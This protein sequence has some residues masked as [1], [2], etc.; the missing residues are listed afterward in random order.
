MAI[1]ALTIDLLWS[2]MP[3]QEQLKACRA[4]WD[5]DSKSKRAREKSLVEQLARS[6]NFHLKFVE[7]KAPLWK[8]ETLFN[9]LKNQEFKPYIGPILYEY[10]YDCKTEMVCAILD[11]EGTSH[12]GADIAENASPP[13][14]DALLRG[15]TAVRG[16]FPDFDIAIYYGYQFV[17]R[18]SR[19]WDAL[20][21][22]LERTAFRALFLSAFAH[23]H[24]QP[25][26]QRTMAGQ[27]EG[28][29]EPESNN[30]FT[31][32]DGQVIKAVVACATGVEGA[33]S[34]DALEDFIQEILSLNL[35]RHRSYFH[36]GY[37]NSIFKR[38][39]S[40]DFSGSNTSRRGWFLTGYLMGQL[41]QP[42]GNEVVGSIRANQRYW[43]ELLRE[44]PKGCTSML[45]YP[46]S[47]HLASAAEWPMLREFLQSVSL[48][49]SESGATRVATE[50]YEQSAEMIRTDRQSDAAPLLHVLVDAIL[51]SRHLSKAFSADLVAKCYRKLGQAELR[52][53]RFAQ[54]KAWLNKALNQ[55]NF[56]QAANARADLGLAEA[57]FRSLKFILPKRDEH[58]EANET[59]VSALEGAHELFQEALEANDPTNAHFVL[60][61]I[62]FHRARPDEAELHLTAAYEG[63]LKTETA[64][65]IDFLID[66]VRLL[67]GIV[68][69]EGCEQARLPEVRHHID[70]AIVSPEFFPLYLWERLC[71]AVSVYDDTSLLEAII[72]HLLK[73]RGD[74]A[75]KLLRE[76][77]LLVRDP[78]LRNSYKEWLVT[79]KLSPSERGKEL[80]MLLVAA[81]DN[82]CADEA[83]ELLDELE[84]V[85]KTDS[86]FSPAFLSFLNR[87]RGRLLALWDESD[88]ISCEA[89]LLESLGRYDEATSAFVKLFH[90]YRIDGDW[91]AIEVALDQ[92]HALGLSTEERSDLERRVNHLRPVSA[93]NADS[94]LE[95]YGARVLYVGGN[96]IQM[97]YENEIKQRLGLKFP[98]LEMDFY[99]PGWGSNWNIHLEKV[100]RL[101]PSYHVVVINSLV[102]T[103]FGRQLRK[104]CGSNIPWL[105]CTGRGRDSIEKSIEKA[106][107][108]IADIRA[109]RAVV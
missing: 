34:E 102:R 69:S 46:L 27:Q 28:L 89:A 98:N 13:D 65:Q 44:G 66:W 5:G 78:M 17:T 30:D 50:V 63:M 18:V 7:K 19:H 26:E 59:T 91:A 4:F 24:V 56:S 105:P 33:L 12:N 77:G 16:R 54:A 70:R 108:W 106:A 6:L 47:L 64:Y 15:L 53:G 52:V 31:T 101:L 104:S 74:P 1:T 22:A 38:V 51:K 85:A 37:F 11:G 90:K 80:E 25:P 32:L 97:Q 73:K 86:E 92:L 43:D 83:F 9:L 68:V 2:Y 84:G 71:R 75:F 8:T 55:E 79:R 99:F 36:L 20:P 81:L 29:T 93:L 61:W 39:A 67:L 100:R 58:K 103:E 95:R 96:E 42:N 94:C 76:S 23:D 35:E 3:P 107:K 57:Q 21:E 60:G 45:V 48:P 88:L 82:G 10:L 72:R 87:E 109:N 40:F 14:V 49:Q 62:A 41:R